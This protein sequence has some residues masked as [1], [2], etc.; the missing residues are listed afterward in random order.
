MQ[1]KTNM[2]IMEILKSIKKIFD[3]KKCDSVQFLDLRNV[4]SYLS[5]FAIATAKT[6]TQARSCAREIEKFM[7]PLAKS[8]GRMSGNS[9]ILVNRDDS[10]WLLLDYGEIIIHIMEPG[11]RE[12]YNLERLWGDARFFDPMSSAAEQSTEV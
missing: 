11:I 3:E 1:R 7:K 9:H 10:G 8:S 6:S 12:Y 2:E 4:N 5:Y